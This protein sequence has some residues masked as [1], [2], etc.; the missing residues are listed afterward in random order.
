VRDGSRSRSPIAKASAKVLARL[1]RAAELYRRQIENGLEGDPR[2]SL[3]ARAVL[4]NLVVNGKIVLTP[5][6][7]G[8]LWA[9]YSLA[10]AVLLKAAAGV[11]SDT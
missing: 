8:S 9:R 3:K 5:G 7:G 10:P 6:E 11:L 1:P 2:E 4:R